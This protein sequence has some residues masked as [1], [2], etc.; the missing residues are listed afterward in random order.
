MSETSIQFHSGLRSIGGTVVTVQYKDAR[1]IFDFGLTYNPAN[2]IFDG[3]IKHRETAYVRDYLRLGLIPAIDGIYAKDDLTNLTEIKAADED[4]RQTAVFVSHLH[5]DHMGAI[6]FLAPSIPVYMTDESLRLY[7]LLETLEESVPGRK[8]LLHACSYNSP[9]QVGDIQVTSLVLDH[10][11]LGACALH[12][13]TP[14]TSILYTGDLRMH[15]AQ[16]KRIQEFIHRAKE[17]TYDVVIM[18]GTTLRSVDE[19]ADEDIFADDSIPEDMLTELTIPSVV[20]EELRKTSDWAVFNIYHRNLD[21]VKGMI[22]AGQQANRLTIFEPKTA[23]LAYKLIPETTNYGVYVSSET[24]A[25]IHSKKLP[26]WKEELLS[27]VTNYHTHTINEN[28]E[29]FFLQNSYDNA[30]EMLDL[31]GGGI[32]IHSNGVPLGMFD[33]AYEN[34][35]RILSIVQFNHVVIGTSGHAIPQHLKHIVDEL[36]PALLIPLHSH[37]PE[38]LK[39]KTG[40]QFLPEFGVVYKLSNHYITTY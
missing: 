38:R 35:K 5:L 24:A 1:V 21:R 29:H 14:D 28:P 9:I 10:D 27:N 13:Q 20:A 6:G 7:N 16:P 30:L 31:K 33:P 39:S 23:Y 8:P 40:E 15:G 18:E 37:Y 12:I 11:V 25:Q 32:Y 36:D 22:N 26:A 34:L 19:L 2:N 17:L 3:Q 4:E